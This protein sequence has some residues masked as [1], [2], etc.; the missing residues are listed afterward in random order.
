MTYHERCLVVNYLV[1]GISDKGSLSMHGVKQIEENS[2]AVA[3]VLL[4]WWLQIDQRS[5][6]LGDAASSFRNRMI[7]G[8]IG[9]KLA[10]PSIRWLRICGHVWLKNGWL[11]ANQLFGICNNARGQQV[12]FESWTYLL[13]SG[14][15]DTSRPC[16][17]MCLFFVHLFIDHCLFVFFFTFIYWCCETPERSSEPH[18]VATRWLGV[19]PTGGH[20]CDLPM[21]TDSKQWPICPLMRLQSIVNCLVVFD[22]FVGMELL[23]IKHVW[24]AIF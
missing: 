7:A 3:E 2:D 4:C 12:I 14:G 18:F 8:V 1:L 16:V 6:H 21:I 15:Q 23:L 22:R 5:V 13:S 20:C 9:M 19:K 17:I 10:M 24:K 11:H